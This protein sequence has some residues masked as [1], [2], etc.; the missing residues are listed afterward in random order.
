V[1]AIS[2]GLRPTIHGDGEQTRDLFAVQD[3][4]MANMLALKKREAG[5]ETLNVGIRME[6]SLNSM[7]SLLQ[8]I[9]G[10]RFKLLQDDE[11]EADI[12]RNCADIARIVD[13]VDF[14]PGV[15]LRPDRSSF[16]RQTK[17]ESDG[18]SQC[19]ALLGRRQTATSVAQFFLKGITASPL[20]DVGST[21]IPIPFPIAPCVALAS[22]LLTAW[23][24]NRWDISI[25]TITA[26]ALRD[27]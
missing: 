23:G 25:A 9:N 11:R 18:H 5:L 8:S 4:A 20:S 26:L 21:S 2:R 24:R 13:V 17:R 10:R 16:C 7:V 27:M 14:K 12:R 15:P 1:A 6:N 19:Q 3:V 22:R